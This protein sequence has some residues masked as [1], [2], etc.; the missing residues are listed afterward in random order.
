MAKLDNQAV[1]PEERQAAGRSDLGGRRER[2]SSKVESEIT[3]SEP[4]RREE[5]REEARKEIRKEVELRKE[6]EPKRE[7]SPYRE[8]RVPSKP[9][10]ENKQEKNEN[11]LC[12]VLAL[13]KELDENEL[14]LVKRDVERKL[15]G[16]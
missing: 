14:E 10:K 16:R 2:E 9:K 11:I 4:A 1:S 3:P 12:A 7:P 13:L 5:R 15:A 8:H 6:N